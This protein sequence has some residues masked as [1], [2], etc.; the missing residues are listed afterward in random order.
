MSKF[1]HGDML[2]FCIH[3]DTLAVKVIVRKSPCVA[4]AKILPGLKLELLSADLMPRKNALGGEPSFEESKLHWD[5]SKFAMRPPLP[6]NKVRDRVTLADNSELT[7]SWAYFP[8]QP[9]LHHAGVQVDIPKHLPAIGMSTSL[10]CAGDRVLMHGDLMEAGSISAIYRNGV[11][12]DWRYHKETYSAVAPEG[13]YT[14]KLGVLDLDEPDPLV[15]T[16][17]LAERFK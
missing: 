12:S 16:V 8:T 7:A 5:G 11:F 2:G 9:V 10:Q 6:G 1:F 14:L 3:G 13:I 15:K 17:K 4:L